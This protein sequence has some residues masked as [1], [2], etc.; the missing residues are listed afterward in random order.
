GKIKAIA[1]TTAKRSALLP[2]VPTMA[3]SGYSGINM[4]TWLMLAAP[5]GLP[6]DVKTRLEKALAVSM[7]DPDTR[8][9]LTAQGLEPDY[10]N[11]AAASELINRELPLM[12][13]VAARAN[14]TAD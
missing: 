1:L 2:D 6:A 14:I 11:A 9:K 13:A 12:R 4:D 3:E 8:A 10:S 5:K 7:A